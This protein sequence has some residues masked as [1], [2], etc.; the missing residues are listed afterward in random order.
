MCVFVPLMTTPTE[1]WNLYLEAATTNNNAKGDVVMIKF[2]VETIWQDLFKD[3]F[4]SSSSKGHQRSLDKKV[5]SPS[6]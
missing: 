1:Q 5:L 2:V 3:N 6:H 4:A